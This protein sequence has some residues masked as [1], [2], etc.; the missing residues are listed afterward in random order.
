MVCPC[1]VIFLSEVIAH[2]R[3][4]KKKKKR[5]GLSNCE[6]RAKKN[7]NEHSGFDVM[8]CRAVECGAFLF[9]GTKNGDAAGRKRKPLTRFLP[10]SFTHRMISTRAGEV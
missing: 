7:K 4:K 3:S 1:E 8:W 6:L 2:T 9:D 5:T 10:F